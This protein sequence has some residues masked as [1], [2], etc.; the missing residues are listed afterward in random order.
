ME[1]LLEDFLPRSKDLPLYLELVVLSGLKLPYLQT[2]AERI[3]LLDV[4]SPINLPPA[5]S[6][7]LTTAMPSLRI[8]RLAVPKLRTD[9]FTIPSTLFQQQSPSLTEVTLTNVVFPDDPCPAFSELH[10]FRYILS[11]PVSTLTLP[12]IFSTCSSLQHLSLDIPAFQGNRAPH[13]S[14][15]SL[16]SVSLKLQKSVK[17]ALALFLNPRSFPA[18]RD[19]FLSD[20]VSGRCLDDIATPADT[21]SIAAPAELQLI[22]RNGTRLH[23]GHVYDLE[24]GGI[25]PTELQRLAVPSS[26][27]AKVHMDGAAGA[28]SDIVLTVDNL[29]RPAG[30][31]RLRCPALRQVQLVARSGRVVRVSDAAVQRFL[32]QAMESPPL[33]VIYDSTVV[34]VDTD[35]ERAA[36]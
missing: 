21:M 4:S 15:P 3:R 31:A 14:S 23:I 13:A 17:G 24:F 36:T 35:N 22:F 16:L 33:D 34:V 6:I 32:A 25:I 19:V 2:H 10:I 7:C 29:R 18:L 5:A 11:Q 30:G 20:C 9:H 8:L 1:S 26:L 12:H 27:L 28:L